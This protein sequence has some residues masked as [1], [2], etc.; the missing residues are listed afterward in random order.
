MIGHVVATDCSYV[1]R[2][3][4]LD[5]HELAIYIAAG[6]AGFL[7]VL[8]C[9]AI[10]CKGPCR[11]FDEPVKSPFEMYMDPATRNQALQTKYELYH[12]HLMTPKTPVERHEIRVPA[13]VTE[14]GGPT[15]SAFDFGAVLRMHSMDKANAQNGRQAKYPLLTK[16]QGDQGSLSS[17]TTGGESRN[18][19]KV[20][21]DIESNKK[22]ETSVPLMMDSNV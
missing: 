9:L 19:Y 14:A 2:K 20:N 22:E 1:S 15:T 4:F 8:W 10:L 7:I 13:Q 16:E 3:M 6:L 21:V 17:D 12:Y 18:I 11:S 5:D